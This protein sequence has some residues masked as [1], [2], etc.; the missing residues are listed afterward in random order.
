[1]ILISWYRW[2]LSQGFTPRTCDEQRAL[3]WSLIADDASHT[4][5]KHSLI[6][7]IAD[8]LDKILE[9]GN[10]NSSQFFVYV[11]GYGQFFNEETT[12]CNDVTF[13]RKANPH[14]DGQPHTRLT[15]ELRADFNAMSRLLNEAIKKAC[16]LADP[17]KARYVDIDAM[18]DGH[19]FCEDGVS[20]PDQENANTY[21]FHYPYGVDDD[22]DPAIQYLNE[23]HEASVSSLEWDPQTTLWSDYLNAFY[24][25][26]DEEGLANA[27]EGDVD[28][29]YDI[30]PDTIGYRAK[31]FHPTMAF[32]ERIYRQ[33]VDQ[34]LDDVHVDNVDED[35]E[36]D[37]DEEE[38]EEEITCMLFDDLDT[39]CTPFWV[40]HS[41]VREGQDAS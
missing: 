11:T 15:T 6:S 41:F 3:S 25:E 37:E 18:L 2:P 24:G 13:A 38:E 32:H 4:E 23:V 16:S 17:R 33:I 21:F 39:V 26:V 28:A 35:D 31:L 29:A 30:W 10:E 9:L 5:P 14:D 22:D 1:M 19:R 12:A 7:K 40:S 8:V 27:L 20:E 34:Y 36:D